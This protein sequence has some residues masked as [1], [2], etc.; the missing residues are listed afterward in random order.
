[1]TY[2]K[3]KMNMLKKAWPKYIQYL[4]DWADDHANLESAEMSPDCWDGWFDC[5]YDEDED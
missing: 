1:M 5:E 2:S 4:H 3:D